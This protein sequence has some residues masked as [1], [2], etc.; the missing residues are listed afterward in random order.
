MKK[1]RH[2]CCTVSALQQ[3]CTATVLSRSS[4]FSVLN[5]AQSRPTFVPDRRLFA[6]AWLTSVASVPVSYTRVLIS[7]Q[8]RFPW[9]KR[10]SPNILNRKGIFS[11][12]RRP[13]VSKLPP[14]YQISNRITLNKESSQEWHLN[15]YHFELKIIFHWKIRR[16]YEILPCFNNFTYIYT[17]WCLFD[18]VFKSSSANS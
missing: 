17:C 14:C 11:Q 4:N 8:G 13:F 1:W 5:N 10:S 16:N 15:C 3:S 12:Q 7:C 9:R 2:F 18:T 6:R